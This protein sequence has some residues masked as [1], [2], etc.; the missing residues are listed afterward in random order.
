M[1]ITLRNIKMVL[2]VWD[3]IIRLIDFIS[4]LNEENCATF[5]CGSHLFLIIFL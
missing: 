5:D 2:Y 3:T 4:N 1:F